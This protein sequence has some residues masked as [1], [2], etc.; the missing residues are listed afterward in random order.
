[1]MLAIF[2]PPLMAIAKQE[3]WLPSRVRKAKERK[4]PEAK[5]AEEGK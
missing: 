5:A 1:M 4:E 2:T 3:G